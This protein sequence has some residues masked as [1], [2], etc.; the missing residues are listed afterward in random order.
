MSKTKKFASLAAALIILGAVITGVCFS[1]L[2]SRSGVIALNLKEMRFDEFGSPIKSLDIDVKDKNIKLL[3]T[4]DDVFSVEYF[5][6]YGSS[7]SVGFSDGK[8][9]IR[10]V[11]NEWLIVDGLFR[12]LSNGEERDVYVYL[13]ERLTGNFNIRITNG[14][15]T[16]RGVNADGGFTASL[17]NGNVHIAD[18]AF[19]NT[20][21]D[22][23]NGNIKIR[24]LNTGGLAAKSANGNLDIDGAVIGGGDGERKADINNTNGNISIKN[25]AAGSLKIRSVNGLIDASAI[26]VTHTDVSLA[27]GTVKITFPDAK[28]NYSVSTSV[29]AGSSNVPTAPNPG[30]EKSVSVGVKAGS[31]KLYFN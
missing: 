8:L 4:E 10:E 26:D 3:H 6:Y 30:A 22:N 12:L 18:A 5:D 15:L 16:A 31:I 17:T 1:I 2:R 21:I 11:K 20:E 13:P 19:G 29:N 28:S 14:D 23:V 25:L 24:N 7:L 27:N 9:S